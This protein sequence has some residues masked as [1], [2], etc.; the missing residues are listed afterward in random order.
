MII[1]HFDD[2]DDYYYYYYYY[3]FCYLS[4][5]SKSHPDPLLMLMLA[6][7]MICSSKSLRASTVQ[8]SPLWRHCIGQLMQWYLV[9]VFSLCIPIIFSNYC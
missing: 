5:A 6:A 3:Y 8:L 9:S 4:V 1:L 7:I 2:D